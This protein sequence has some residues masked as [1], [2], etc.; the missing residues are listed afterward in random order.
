V[1]LRGRFRFIILISYYKYTVPTGQCHI[2]NRRCL[3][4]NRRPAWRQT[5]NRKDLRRV[6][7]RCLTS[8]GSAIQFGKLAASLCASSA[9]FAVKT[10]KIKNSELNDIALQYSPI[11]TKYWENNKC[12]YLPKSL[13]DEST[14]R[15]VRIR[16]VGSCKLN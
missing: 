13:T 1:L 12:P 6:P 16:T 15:L 8:I 14:I 10:F 7:Q 11:M 2:V 5:G 4:F 9:N 3:E